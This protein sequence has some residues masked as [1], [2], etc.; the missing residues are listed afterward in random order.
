MGTHERLGLPPCLFH[1]VTGFP[2]FSCGMTTSWAWM[3]HGHPWLS[4]KTQPMGAILFV[5]TVF[6]GAASLVFLFTGGSVE[7]RFQK[8]SKVTTIAFWVG[9]LAGW[10]YKIIV[11][12]SA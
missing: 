10:V 1:K 11:E 2:C 7:R 5:A 12:K 8:H 3:A 6:A 4:F 9:L